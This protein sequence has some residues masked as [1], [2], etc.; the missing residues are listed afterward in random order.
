M[1]LLS[2]HT[3]I[4]SL[5][6]ACVLNPA[7]P[8]HAA[9]WDGL[10]NAVSKK[11]AEKEADLS[12]EELWVQRELKEFAALN[13]LYRKSGNS[14]NH[15]KAE[16]RT[17][18]LVRQLRGVYTFLNTQ[19]G[20][21]SRKKNQEVT[22][23]SLKPYHLA[24]RD[25]RMEIYRN[26]L[27]S[28]RKFIKKSRA[29]MMK[30]QPISCILR[31]HLYTD[32]DK[33]PNRAITKAEAANIWG[34]K[35]VKELDRLLDFYPDCKDEGVLIE[36][37]ALTERILDSYAP[38]Y[39]EIQKLIPYRTYDSAKNVFGVELEAADL[40]GTHERLKNSRA[41]LYRKFMLNKNLFNRYAPMYAD[42]LKAI[43]IILVT[44]QEDVAAAERAKFTRQRAQRFGL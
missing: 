4:L 17:A 37:L 11:I 25:Q 27:R 13:S 26:F 6:A 32:F 31:T 23:E 8:A 9:P 28:S 22:L 12:K 43:E 2:P 24:Q 39:P 3:V 44:H 36:T 21:D 34:Q 38:M 14:E 20:K 35:E 29:D 33:A 30:V 41:A 1:N 18:T 15:E 42:Y 7:V 40:A 5:L 19:K 10:K 16:E